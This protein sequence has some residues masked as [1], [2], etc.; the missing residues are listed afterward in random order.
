MDADC[1]WGNKIDVKGETT[2]NF[3]ITG[4]QPFTNTNL[5]QK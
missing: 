3:V 5:K 1:K 4:S 2:F